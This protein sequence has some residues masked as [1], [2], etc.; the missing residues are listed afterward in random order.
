MLKTKKK[1]R[2]KS[3]TYNGFCFIEVIRTGLEPVTYCLAY[4][5]QF[6]LLSIFLSRFVVWTL[7]S[8]CFD[9]R[10]LGGCR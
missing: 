5:L 7:S 9:I 10:N 3:L 2:H 4:Q 1:N 6:S 8:P